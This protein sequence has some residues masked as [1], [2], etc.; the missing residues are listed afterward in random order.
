METR[1]LL[2]GSGFVGLSI[3]VWGARRKTTLAVRSLLALGIALV[4]ASLIVWWTGGG[5][6]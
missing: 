4:V 2:L 5:R 6:A 3:A 1:L